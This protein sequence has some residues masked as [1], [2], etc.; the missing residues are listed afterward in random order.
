MNSLNPFRA[1][2]TGGVK[3][4]RH[5]VFKM[6]LYSQMYFNV[7]RKTRPIRNVTTPKFNMVFRNAMSKR[8]HYR[9]GRMVPSKTHIWFLSA[10]TET[11]DLNH[12]VWPW[13]FKTESEFHN[14][15]NGKKDS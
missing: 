9:P 1:I 5:P 11:Q 8:I 15:Y 10:I 6:D 13:E 12:R 3:F 4:K 7:A 2:T 14:V